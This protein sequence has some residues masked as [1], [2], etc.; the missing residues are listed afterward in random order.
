MTR[1]IDYLLDLAF[2]VEVT[3]ISVQMRHVLHVQLDMHLLEVPV[4]FVVSDVLH[5]QLLQLLWY[6]QH[7]HQDIIFQLMEYA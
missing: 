7:A 4:T 5:A 3:A 6:A 1:D 2:P